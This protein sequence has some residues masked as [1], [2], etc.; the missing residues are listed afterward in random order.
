MRLNYSFPNVKQYKNLRVAVENKDNRLKIQVSGPKAFFLQYFFKY[1]FKVYNS[2]DPV[3][4]HDGSYI[5]TL[6]VPPIPSEAHARHFEDFI[7]RWMFRT[8]IP[9]AATISVTNRCQYSC[10]HCSVPAGRDSEPELSLE[11]LKRIVAEC[12]DLGMTNITFTGGEPLLFAGLEELLRS[13]PREKAVALVFTNAKDLSAE[14]ARSLKEAGAWG[15]QISLDSPVPAEHDKL[16]MPGSFECVE[17]GVK[18]AREAGLLVGLSTYAT[19]EFV[20]KKQA[21]RY[22]RVGRCLGSAGDQCI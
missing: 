10:P 13:I 21:D 4:V 9:L 8:R 6:Y 22:R 15:I 18:A 3:A 11:E 7:R 5:Y 14:K 12:L 2:M 1:Y 16:R 19:N 20:K 17:E